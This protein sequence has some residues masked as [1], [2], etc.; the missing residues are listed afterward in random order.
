MEKNLHILTR[1]EDSTS[2]VY[3]EKAV[4]EKR[5]SGLVAYFGNNAVF[6][7][8]SSIS[9][10][11]L[12]P[13]TSVTHG[14]MSVIA[15]SGASVSWVG[16]GSFKFYATGGGRTRSSEN[17]LV[18]AKAWADKATRTEVVRRMYQKRFDGELDH[19]LTIAQIRGKE[20][21]RVRDVYAQASQK[22]AVPW[23]GRSYKL[24]SWNDSDPVNKCLSMGSAMLYGVC[25]SAISALGFS[26][27]LGFIHTGKSLSFVYDIADLY[28]METVVPA[29]FEAVSLGTESAESELRR[30]LRAKFSEIDLMK[31][32]S[33]DIPLLFSKL[34]VSSAALQDL[35]EPS[36]ELW[37]DEG[38][39]CGGVNYAGNDA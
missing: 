35:N 21:A 38:S 25:H 32:L 18:Q 12:G 29:A 26:P 37:G 3:L 31:S 5:D 2:F 22:Y 33:T 17:T 1:L 16:E 28:K 10:I 9:S 19:K 4:L 36:I 11:A 6:L 23:N 15:E 8:T 13:G 14:A 27:A 20:G 30:L 24:S 34:R 39:V 7:P